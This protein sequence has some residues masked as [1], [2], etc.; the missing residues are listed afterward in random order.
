MAI[1]LYIVLH[2]NDISST[3][4]D[5][6]VPYNLIPQV[7]QLDVAEDCLSK[8]TDL[9]WLS[10]FLCLPLFDS[11][12]DFMPLNKILQETKTLNKTNHAAT[13]ARNAVVKLF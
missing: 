9:K 5:E 8:Q 7:V 10:C 1:I 2:H 12:I 4:D 3:C 11:I 6:S 13:R